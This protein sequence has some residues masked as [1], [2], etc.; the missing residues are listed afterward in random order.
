MHLENFLTPQDIR[1][2][3]GHLAVETA[4][5][6]QCGIQHIG[7]VG[8]GD[9][10]HAFVCFE[11]I[12]FHKQLV[13]GLLAL[14]IAA[15]Q[16]GAAMAADR[17]NF[18]DENDAGCVF[19]ALFE[20]I[21]DTACADTNEHLDEIRTRNCEE[22]HVRLASDGSRQQ[23]LAGTRRAHQQTASRDLAAKALKFLGIPKEFDDL[24]QFELRLVDTRNIVECYAPRL[25]GQ[26]LGFRLAE[27][28][29]L[30]ATALHLAHKKYPDA[31]EKQEGEISQENIHQRSRTAV[32]FIDLEAHAALAQR[33]NQ[34]IVTS[35]RP[36]EKF[37][38]AV[39][40]MSFDT[41]ALDDNVVYFAGI[42]RLKE[43][44][45]WDFLFGLHPRISVEEAKQ[46]DQ[47]NDD[48][49]PDC[50]ISTKQIHL[51]DPSIAGLNP[52][53]DT[54]AR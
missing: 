25:F 45:I 47:Q 18:I 28:H 20:H 19:L 30:A 11:A 4:R 26:Q 38:R 27:A 34:R 24:L 23:R 51:C 16:A 14:V 40:V 39:L 32:I 42:D 9:Q 43:I 5:A 53:Y 50:Q 6:Q 49:Y 44:R 15:T 35:R 21:P 10:D 7:P 46:C 13:Q 36:G 37:P 22:G 3:H 17:V 48:K 41:G 54:P 12:H 31:N 8:C 29:R 1:V 52:P 2:G 33:F